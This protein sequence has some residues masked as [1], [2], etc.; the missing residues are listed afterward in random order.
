M[1]VGEQVPN[2]CIM[3]LKLLHYHCAGF[4]AVTGRFSGPASLEREL[5]LVVVCK[6][7]NKTKQELK[8]NSKWRIKLCIIILA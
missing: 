4:T 8:R 5:K 2:H 7:R 1:G 3:T 6:T